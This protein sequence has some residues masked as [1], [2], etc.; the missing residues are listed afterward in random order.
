MWE[1]FLLKESVP[2]YWY[3]FSQEKRNEKPALSSHLALGNNGSNHASSSCGA[4][5]DENS[6]TSDS[7]HGDLSGKENIDAKDP[8]IQN[9]RLFKLFLGETTHSIMVLLQSKL[10]IVTSMRKSVPHKAFLHRLDYNG[11]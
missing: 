11:L 6:K 10:L 9:L 8:R 4:H 2:S 7:H 3:N 1:N 5:N